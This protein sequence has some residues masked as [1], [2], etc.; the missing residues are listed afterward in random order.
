MKTFR[1]GKSP[2][3]IIPVCF[4]VKLQPNGKSCTITRSEDAQWQR[5][6][7][8]KPMNKSLNMTANYLVNFGNVFL[9][10]C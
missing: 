6:L 2:V 1:S 7:P 10:A 5:F 4:R 3:D 9:A 8:R